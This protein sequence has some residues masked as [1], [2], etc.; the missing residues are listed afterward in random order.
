MKCKRRALLLAV[1]SLLW[2]LYL[3]GTRGWDHS[4]AAQ[5]QPGRPAPLQAGGTPQQQRL[6]LAVVGS[7][8]QRTST[9]DRAQPKE[10]HDE[11]AT[12]PP[13]LAPAKGTS[14]TVEVGYPGSI[15]Q[16]CASISATVDDAWCSINCNHNPP[17]CPSDVCVCVGSDQQR[18]S[19]PHQDYRQGPV[20]RFF[21]GAQLEDGRGCE[22]A[23]F[24][25]ATPRQLGGFASIM[26][27][28][29]WCMQRAVASHQVFAVDHHSFGS[30]GS[31]SAAYHKLF[32]S[33]TG[34]P[35]SFYNASQPIE[36]SSDY[37]FR[38]RRRFYVPPAALPPSVSQDE[39]LGHVLR[40]LLRP[41][42]YFD[43]ALKQLKAEIEYPTA[44]PHGEAV[45]GI[46]VRRGDKIHDQIS[47]VPLAR[48][49]EAAI[50]LVKQSQ[51]AALK[52]PALP[53]PSV[54]FVATDDPSW[55]DMHAEMQRLISLAAAVA[56][57]DDLPPLTL[58]IVSHAQHNLRK[59]SMAKYLDSLATS[60]SQSE[61][62]AAADDEAADP[63]A[64]RERATME[65][66]ADLLLLAES[67]Y[68]IGSSVLPSSCV[69]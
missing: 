18:T 47:A 4:A 15:F 21:Q 19:A 41:T 61:G 39:W 53:V 6:P 12:P 11:K 38:E 5:Q 33:E 65:I 20:G 49:M 67:E 30:Y 51:L 36:S 29:A 7:D 24:L 9:P 37:I 35:Y 54:I 52:N 13:E 58:R 3:G 10:T 57:D 26:I 46:H 40:W 63:D 32:K 28:L 45:I 16:Q 44:H 50:Q 43:R 22:K 55:E 1:A 68:L 14:A 25:V 59:H 69:V 23:E 8:Q 27:T 2:G 66:A 64:V 62:A 17:F 31:S 42:E 34:C 60:E 48:Y 56:D